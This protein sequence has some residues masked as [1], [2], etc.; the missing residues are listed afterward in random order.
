MQ[1][2]EEARER[3][4]DIA[5]AGRKILN[6]IGKLSVNELR[7]SPILRAAI[8]REFIIVGEALRQAL[9]E[10][11]G[12]TAAITGTSKIVGFR[13]V[14]VH[15]YSSINVDEVWAIIQNDLPLLLAE[16]RSLLGELPA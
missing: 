9:Q 12:V 1:L 14:L 8:E 5:A 10:D 11:S 15:N 16:C 13:N 2:N 6:W 4:W 3:L 7:A